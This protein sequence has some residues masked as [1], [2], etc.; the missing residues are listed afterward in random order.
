[1]CLSLPNGA[2]QT[3]PVRSH[4]TL[5][6]VKITKPEWER[7]FDLVEGVSSCLVV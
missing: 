2:G 6:S 7:V 1:M 3:C 4:S 5:A